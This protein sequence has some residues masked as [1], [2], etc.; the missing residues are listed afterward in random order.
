M[1]MA[2]SIPVW[3]AAAALLWAALRKKPA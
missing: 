3:A 2:L 1:G